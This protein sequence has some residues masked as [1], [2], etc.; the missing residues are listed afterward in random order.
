MGVILDR[1][2]AKIHWVVFLVLELLSGLLL[3]RFNSYQAS[4]WATQANAVTGQIMEWESELFAFVN[5]KEQ[6]DLLTQQNQALQMELN[7]LRY[8]LSGRT[9]DSTY[10]EC[11]RNNVLA[12]QH[13]IPARIISNS[14]RSK[15]NFLTINRGSADGVEPEMG[16]VSGT[17]LVGIVSG[18]TP[19]YAMVMSVLNSRSNIS[20]RLRGTN[21]FGYLTWRGGSPQLAYIAD[22]PRHARCE[23]GD[24]VETS[25]YSQVFPQG[26]F[27]GRVSQVRDSQDGLAY[28]LEVK[29]GNDLGNIQ[30]VC[31][32]QNEH[33]AELDSLKAPR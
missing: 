24:T 8:Q 13:I 32:L 5:L 18:V 12:Q 1:L 14:V 2:K 33:K 9:E 4:V 11:L 29:L 26:L 23:V 22:V 7:E 19:H 21:Y 31:V 6:N 16:V 10:V 20:C 25:G 27:I 17:G 28:E 15:D 3:F 30:S